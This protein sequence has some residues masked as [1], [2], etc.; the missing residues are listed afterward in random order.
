MKTI[1]YNPS[2]LEVLF[3]GAL[4]HLKDQISDHLAGNQII[5]V[6]QQQTNDNPMVKFS[7]IDADGDPHEIVIRII[8]IP[9][10]F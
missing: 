9:D 4:D 5:K 10:K 8:Q 7:I 3:A 1:S 2:A 6:Q